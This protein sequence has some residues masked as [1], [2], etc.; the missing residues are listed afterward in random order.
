MSSVRCPLS[1]ALTCARTSFF[2]RA[3]SD[4]PPACSARRSAASMASMTACGSSTTLSSAIAA[5]SCMAITAGALPGHR[6][7]SGTRCGTNTTARP[8]VPMCRI[9]ASASS[10]ASRAAKTT[11]RV[12]SRSCIRPSRQK[13]P[14]TTG[15]GVETA[16]ADASVTA[17]PSRSTDQPRHIASV[18]S[19]LSDSGQE[20]KHRGFS[21]SSD[22][23]T[24]VTDSTWPSSQ[25]GHGAVSPV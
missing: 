9:S 4:T 1:S 22:G 20:M 21:V 23:A 14:G 11:S 6:P 3:S 17:K 13:R 18:T 10:S 16:R 5:T 8:P 2:P 7:G 24:T 12:V 19:T 15:F 25:W